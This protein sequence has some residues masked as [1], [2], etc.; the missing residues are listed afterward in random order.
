MCH[1]TKSIEFDSIFTDNVLMH[2][3]LSKRT[4][5]YDSVH[6]FFFF[7]LSLLII[8][9]LRKYVSKYMSTGHK[10]YIVHLPKNSRV[11][12]IYLELYF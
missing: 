5:V 2:S 12:I 8:L 7:L 9:L 1:F 4:Y 3:M 11:Q 10:L 6:V